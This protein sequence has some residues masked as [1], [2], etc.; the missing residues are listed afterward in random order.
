MMNHLVP[1]L[2]H[3]QNFIPLYF[4]M[5]ETERDNFLTHVCCLV[6]RLTVMHNNKSPFSLLKMLSFQQDEGKI[7]PIV[8]SH[9]VLALSAKIN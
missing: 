5:L 1:E 3:I 6:L 4:Q 2:I 7:L 9:A 8:I